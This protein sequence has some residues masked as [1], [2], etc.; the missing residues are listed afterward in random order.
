LGD[1][2]RAIETYNQSIV[3]LKQRV[4]DG[5]CG[6]PLEATRSKAMEAKECL[7]T[8][9]RSYIIRSM[10]P[11][12]EGVEARRYLENPISPGKDFPWLYWRVREWARQLAHVPDSH[13]RTFLP[14]TLQTAL[15]SSM[16]LED[17]LKNFGKKHGRIKSDYNVTRL[18][19]L[20]RLRSRETPHPKFD[21]IEKFIRNRIDRA[22]HDFSGSM[23]DL[24]DY[25]CVIFAN[26]KRTIQALSRVH[27]D[28]DAVDVS[29]ILSARIRSRRND[30]LQTLGIPSEEFD[31]EVLNVIK[32]YINRL[33]EEYPIIAESRPNVWDTP[34]YSEVDNEYMHL[35]LL[36]WRGGDNLSMKTAAELKKK[37]VRQMLEDNLRQKIREPLNQFEFVCKLSNS[38]GKNSISWKN[39]LDQLIFKAADR[40]I[41]NPLTFIWKYYQSDDR[42]SDI[43]RER[44]RLRLSRLAYSLSPRKIIEDLSGDVDFPARQQIIDS[45]N[46]DLYP[47]ILICSAVGEEG[48]DLQ[49]RCN[50]VIHYDLEWNPAKVEQR[51][52]RVDRLGR[53]SSSQ[54]EITTYKL[55]ETYDERILARCQARK[56]WMELYLCKTWK[57]EGKK[58]EEEAIQSKSSTPKIMKSLDWLIEYRLDLKP[59][60]MDPSK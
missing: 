9:L 41:R 35:S 33:I 60:A 55:S 53:L 15:S 54:V 5:S 31:R 46:Y 2:E 49:R 12:K 44:L 29:S 39:D 48:I 17:H 27:E 8:L 4:E 57:E 25:K 20:A 7:E 23:E 10:R 18:Q 58:L 38:P 36:E 16:A 51:E 32:R 13:L 26:R 14:T 1:I 37:S 21:E 11:E 42:S 47:L 3:E 30:Q 59:E 43:V 56:V 19:L 28:H 6:D 45:F 52:G 34:Y 22:A 24:A 50:T 40:R